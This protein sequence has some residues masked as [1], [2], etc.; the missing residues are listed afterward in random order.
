MSKKDVLKAYQGVKRSP[1]KTKYEYIDG[2]VRV[3]FVFTK[4]GVVSSVILCNGIL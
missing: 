4:E 1:D 3:E 2:N